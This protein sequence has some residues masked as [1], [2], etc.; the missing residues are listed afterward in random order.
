MATALISIISDCV[1][2]DPGMCRV[3]GKPVSHL[4]IKICRGGD[5]RKIADYFGTPTAPS[6]GT[7]KPS[8]IPCQYLG[9]WIREES[10]VHR[11]A[12]CSGCVKTVHIKIYECQ[13]EAHNGETTIKECQSCVDFVARQSAATA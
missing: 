13:H 7:S 10:G 2:L 4:G 11:T 9:D 1:C 8:F 6:N 12:P 3:R 5:P